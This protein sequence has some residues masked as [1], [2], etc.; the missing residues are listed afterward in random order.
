MTKVPY[1]ARTGYKASSTNTKTWSSYEQAVQAIENARNVSGKPYDGIGYVFNRDVTG[2]DLD[3]CADEQGLPNA[4]AQGILDRLNSYTELSPSGRG[5][6][7]FV[8]GPLPVSVKRP[9]I[10]MYDS[11]RYFTITGKHLEGTPDAIEDRQEQ[12]L[13][14]HAEITAP[15]PKRAAKQQ[16]TAPLTF[17]DND[18]LDKAMKAKDG[19]K[20]AAL[21]RGDT[22]G[23]ASPSEA[24]LAL[25]NLLAFWTGRD[26][27]RMDSLFRRSGLYREEKWDKDARSG[28]TYGEGTIARAIDACT[29]VY[30]PGGN[31]RIVEAFSTSPPQR[32]KSD[33]QSEA[34]EK[35][36]EP[37]AKVLIRLAEEAELFSTPS[38]DRYARLH[39]NG[40]IEAWPISEKGGSFKRWL[41]WRYRSLT[42]GN[43]PNATALSAAIQALEAEAQFGGKPIQEVYLRIASLGE[44]VYLNLA[45]DACEVVEIG[46]KGW[47]ILSQSPLCF[48][49]PNGMLPLPRPIMGGKLDE[50]RPFINVESDNDWLLILAWLLGAFHP[51]GPYSILDLTGER[52]A[53]KSTVTRVLRSLIDPSSAPLRKEPKDDHGLAIMAHNSHVITL[54]NLSHMPAWLSDGLCRLATR[55]GLSTRK[56][57]END[58]ECIFDACRP[59]VFN[60][61]EDVATRGDLLDRCIVIKLPAI[62]PGARVDEKTFYQKFDQAHPRILG[63][64]LDAVSRAIRNLPHTTIADLPRMADFAL[65]VQAAE[66]CLTPKSGAF[67]EAYTSNRE[68]GTSIELEA[69][70]VAKVV[71][72]FMELQPLFEGSPTELER[73]LKE[74]AGEEMA[75]F[76]SWPKDARALS[77]KLKRLAPSL[78]SVGI[79]VRQGR[80][81]ATGRFITIAKSVANSAKS[82]ANSGASV[83]NFSP[84]DTSSNHNRGGGSLLVTQSDA[85]ST[86]HI[87]PPVYRKKEESEEESEGERGYKKSEGKLA[88]LCVTSSDGLYEDE[89]EVIL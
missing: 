43:T 16:H 48:R 9:E 54:D 55:S 75:R 10:E 59:I 32:Q 28:E 26:A 12:V 77:G 60:G 35:E 73:Q 63:A 84:S 81:G 85:N 67:M 30:T 78:R 51:T 13:A 71:L 40:H 8:H 22:S 36:A 46:A 65:W 53:T 66:P 49:R 74:L 86:H 18:L 25:C 47:R 79:D 62:A 44:K 88:S 31:R 57:Y 21:W 89:E 42:G 2:V 20:F 7:I 6:H 37:Q 56:L 83:A 33:P 72:A 82:V 61:I 80:N 23:Y 41:I 15:R 38:G 58:E 5:F 87:Y 50:L 69:S 19:A 3:H 24:D 4:W 70:L 1:N 64:L 11:G 17:S 39:I 68:E 76:P 27:S 29:E 14:L 45:N 34:K 52:G